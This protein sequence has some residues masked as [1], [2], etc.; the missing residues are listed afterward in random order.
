VL[1]GGGGGGQKILLNNPMPPAPRATAL[2]RLRVS[3]ELQQVAARHFIE[4]GDEAEGEVSVKEVKKARNNSQDLFKG[5]E[6][7]HKNYK[8]IGIINIEKL[9]K[10]P[11]QRDREI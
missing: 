6:K 4:K 3:V 2:P 1:K 11:Y 7:Y 5:N 9:Q 8:H 10:N